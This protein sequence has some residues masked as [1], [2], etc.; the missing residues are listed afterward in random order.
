[1]EILDTFKFALDAILPIILLILLGYILKGI[2]FLTDGFLKVGNSFVFNV[3]LPCLLFYNV[4]SIES[5]ESIDWS[6]VLYSEICI[7]LAFVIGALCCKFFV[8]DPRQ[9]G[10]I[11]Q[12]V[13]RSNYAIIG[14]SLATSL[15][16]TNGQAIAALLSAF[17]IPTFN[18]LAVISLTMFD[19]NQNENEKTSLGKHLL[20]TLKGV[21]TNPLIIGVVIGLVVLGIRYAIPTNSDGS[22]VFSLERDCKL[23]FKCVTD[24]ANIASPLAL[25]VLGGMFDFSTVKG[26]LKPIIGGTLSRVLIVPLI[27]IGGAIILSKY[28]N[29]INFDES[30]YPALIALFASPVA[31]SSAIM[32]EQMNNDGKLASQLV[33]WTSLFSII[34]IFGFIVGLRSMALL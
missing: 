30:V 28:T 14:V 6:V 20:K 26:M 33:V 13:F 7:I 32:A 27:G 22:L 19:T 21:V 34:T 5:F 4:Y 9:K 24:L 2:H 25:V 12:C 1:M 15:G 23:F 18:V 17:S 3:C 11:L 29:L 16:G 8:K 31:V 10:V